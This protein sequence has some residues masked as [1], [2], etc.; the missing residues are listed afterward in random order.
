M[1]TERTPAKPKVLAIA[2]SLRA[3]SYTT[4]ILRTALAG[5]ERAG[6]EVTFADLRD[7]PMPIYD[8]DAH[9]REGFDPTALE[10]QGIVAAHD[11]FLVTTPE[12]NGSVS[13]ALKNAIDWASR[14]SDVRPRSTVFL[15]KTAAIMTASPG[16]FGGLRCL[17]HLRAILTSVG[18]HV[19]PT[20]IAV[21][22]VHEMF[23]GDGEVLLDAATLETIEGLGEALVRVL[24]AGSRR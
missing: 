11:G 4:R 21:P 1:T 22:N 18:V 16:R 14:P 8:P 9:E 10:F 12:Y 3:Q 15:G 24:G 20:E 23:D 17:N 6:A 2:G 7:F 19:L 5:A 13:A